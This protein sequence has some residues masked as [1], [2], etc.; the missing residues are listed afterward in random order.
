MYF[1]KRANPKA[2]IAVMVTAVLLVII[3]VFFSRMVSSRRKEAID[4]SR[5]EASSEMA[6]EAYCHLTVKESSDGEVMYNLAAKLSGNSKETVYSVMAQD[7]IELEITPVEGKLFDYAEVM[8]DN[9]A[10]VNIDQTDTG[11]QFIMPSSDA[12]VTVYYMDDEEWLLAHA[13]TETEMEE[14][15]RDM[16]AALQETENSDTEIQ[17]ELPGEKRQEQETANTAEIVM[18]EHQ[19]NTYNLKL[20]NASETNTKDFGNPFIADKL[21]QDIGEDFGV[22]DPGSYYYDISKVTFAN[23]MPEQEE[24]TVKRYLYFEDD[25]TWLILGTYYPVSGIYVFVDTTERKAMSEFPEPAEIQSD[26]DNSEA[27]YAAGYSGGNAV[28]V[29]K[30]VTTTVSLNLQNV[31]TVFLSFVGDSQG[32]VDKLTEYVYSGG[33]SGNVTG[34]FEYYEIDPEKQRATFHISLSTG[35][36]I[37]GT[38]DKNSNSYSFSGM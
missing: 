25:P 37:N 10:Y 36:T 28:T 31:S 27:N 2:I 16:F 22:G 38:Y 4:M 29:P 3:I 5:Y 23:E 1:G 15:T 6:A 19:Y 20:Y 17:E 9:G 34:F 26:G 35:R 12:E 33:S 7:E 30:T 32:F 8:T 11:I 13:E 18:P 24:G 14:Q 21:L